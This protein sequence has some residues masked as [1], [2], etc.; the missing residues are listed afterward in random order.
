MFTMFIH[1]NPEI[2]LYLYYKKYVVVITS[3]VP[4]AVTSNPSASCNSRFYAAEL[5]LKQ[6]VESIFT[7]QHTSFEKKEKCTLALA[8]C[9]YGRKF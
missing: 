1:I 3:K 8:H 7:F 4:Q 6:S 5:L 9:G 2:T